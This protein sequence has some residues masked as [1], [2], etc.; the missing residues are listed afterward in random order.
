MTRKMD[1][2][3]EGCGKCQVCRYLDFLDWC[4]NVGGGGTIQRNQKLEAYLDKHYP[5]WRK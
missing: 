2:K 1:C 4:S 5:W 3:N